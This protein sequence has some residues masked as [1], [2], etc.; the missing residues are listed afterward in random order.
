LKSGKEEGEG[1]GEWKEHWDAEKEGT[2]PHAVKIEL[3][4]EEEGRREGD[5]GEIYYRE[6]IIPLM[7]HVKKIRGRRGRSDR[8]QNFLVFL[9]SFVSFVV[10]KRQKGALP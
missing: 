9:A 4:F 10:P 5:E 6:L 2:L 3:T 7:I 1:E 8:K